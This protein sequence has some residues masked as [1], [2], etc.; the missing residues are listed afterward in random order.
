MHGHP[1]KVIENPLPVPELLAR[2]AQGDA[3]CQY[4]A[5][6]RYFQGE[7]V[8]EDPHRAVELCADAARQHHVR[9]IAFLAYC[10]LRGV[11]VPKDRRAAVLLYRV[12]AGEGYAP[13]QFTLGNF[14]LS[15]FG[16]RRSVRQALKWLERAADQDDVDALVRLGDLH[17]EGKEV[18]EDEERAC[19]CYRRAAELGS[20]RGEYMYGSFLIKGAAVKADPVAALDWLDRAVAQG[21]APAQAVHAHYEEF[22]RFDPKEAGFSDFPVDH[23]FPVRRRTATYVAA[24]GR[25]CFQAMAC[26]LYDYLREHAKDS[27]AAL[28]DAAALLVAATQKGEPPLPILT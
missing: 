21:Y 12:A 5:G 1:R 7:G 14:Y 9:A 13:A 16:V 4:W 15:G 20:A 11:V 19:A 24:L 28:G 2:V 6:L 18:V 23:P 10:R 25:P 26:D 22:V 27:E 17:H 8:P 3:D